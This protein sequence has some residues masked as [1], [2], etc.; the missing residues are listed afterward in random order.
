[1]PFYKLRAN[2]MLLIPVMVSLP[3]PEGINIFRVS[4]KIP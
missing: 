4:L 3:N 2:G 1:M